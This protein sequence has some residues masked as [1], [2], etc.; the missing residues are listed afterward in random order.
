MLCISTYYYTFRQ[1]V[2]GTD[3]DAGLQRSVQLINKTNPS[4]QGLLV[5]LKQPCM[6]P[7]VLSTNVFSCYL[8]SFRWDCI[9]ADYLK[10]LAHLINQLLTGS[11]SAY[12]VFLLNTSFY[13]Q[14][15]N[16]C[17]SLSSHSRVSFCPRYRLSGSCLRCDACLC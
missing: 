5:F 17:D 16:R 9:S 15:T 2:S 13:N 10:K 8:I 3:A 11:T 6:L 12:G 14:K 4:G 1:L 7:A